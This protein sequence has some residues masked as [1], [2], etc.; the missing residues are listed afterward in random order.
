[1]TQ[2]VQIP[3]RDRERF[4]AMVKRLPQYLRLATAILK[5]PDVPK[6][7]KA[8][9][10]LGGAYA[11]SPIDLVPGIIPVAGQLDDAYMLLIGLRQS[12]R[13]MPKDRA[14]MHLNAAGIE[15]THIDEDIDLVVSI[16]GRIARLVVTAGVKIGRA[17]KSTYQFAAER[18]RRKVQGE[19]SR[20]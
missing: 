6:S 18:I 1:M 10:G 4:A 7:S 19:S 2:S 15:M 3:V 16:A 11:V 14:Q 8:L 17:G 13:G 5:D 20:K 9:L 12:L